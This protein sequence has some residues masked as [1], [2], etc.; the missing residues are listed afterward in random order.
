MWH[1]CET[2]GVHTGTWWGELKEI[3][4]LE[5]LGEDEEY[6][7]TPVSRGNTFQDLPRLRKT[8]VIPKAIYN[9]IF[10]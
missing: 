10:V 9:M 1:A 7:W 8:A 2:G 5:E 6:R 4:H 3:D